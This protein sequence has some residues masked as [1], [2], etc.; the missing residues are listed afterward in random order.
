MYEAIFERVE[1]KYVIS[2][3]QKD[4]LLKKIKPF[5]KKDKYYQSMICNIYFDSLNNDL[6]RKSLDKPVWKEKIRLRS[7]GIPRLNDIVYLE[8]KSK[9]KEIVS[10]RRV[11]MSLEEFYNYLK[12]KNYLGNNQIKKELDYCFKYYDLKPKIFI[13]YDRL[14]FLGKNEDV[15]ITFDANLR[16]RR[17]D[18]NLELGDAGI[19]YFNNNEIILEIKTLGS[20]PLWLVKSLT[21]LKIWPN[22]FSKYG[23]IYE[24]EY[25]NL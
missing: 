13:A 17:D 9:Y 7:Y 21:E 3:E 22:S 25:D 6:I 19:K 10:K 16:S 5:I 8:K 15:R 18:L 1:K 11:G 20:M 12:D 23:H 24:K 4:N 2:L 14:S